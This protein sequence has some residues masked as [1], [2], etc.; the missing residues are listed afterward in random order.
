M[1]AEDFFKE[2][3][4]EIQVTDQEIESA[5]EKRDE[6][7]ATV[8]AILREFGLR[9]IGGFAAGALAA[10]TQIKP[11]NDVDLVVYASRQSLPPAWEATPSK[12][13]TDICAR[14]G[15]KSG[16]KCEPRAHAVKVTFPDVEFTADVVFGVERSP[17]GLL[18]PH[19]PED[20]VHDWIETD[21]KR[22]AE[23]VRERNG[24]TNYLFARVVR[25]MKALNKYWSFQNDDGDNAKPVSSF[26]M[27]ALAWWVATE[28]PSLSAGVMTI[29]DKGSELVA[30]AIKDPSGVGDPIAAKDPVLAQSKFVEARDAVRRALQAG[31]AA[32][33]ILTEVFGEQKVIRAIFENG[34]LAITKSTGALIS[35]VG[36]ATTVQNPR[37]TSFGDP[38]E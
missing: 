31:D 14:L 9:G 22:H 11:L 20:S 16:Y 25:I 3:L 6:L 24:E 4:A 34:P 7:R 32:D 38:T 18:I 36:S 13:L 15:E 10:G 17:S 19:C 21:P 27:T 23:L 33:K 12:A 35:G 28:V 8:G 29:L 1:N 26:H 30:G 2:L 5:R 37:R